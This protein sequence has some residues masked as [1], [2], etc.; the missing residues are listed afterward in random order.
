MSKIK[1]L[2]IMRGLPGSGKSFKAKQLGINGVVFSTDEY[3]IIDG[4]YILKL[5]ELPNAHAWNRE[6]AI[7]SI[8]DGITPIVIDNTNVKAW[9]PRPYVEAGLLHG[10]DVSIEYA[11]TPWSF[12]VDELVK[13]NNHNVSKAVIEGMLANFKMDLTVDDIMK[14]EMPTLPF[15]KSE[16]NYQRESTD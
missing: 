7:A 5:D 10:Y 4:K 3:F 6:R 1:K 9:E 8:K 13:R 12:D 14:S 16:S 2:Y 15:C 11:G